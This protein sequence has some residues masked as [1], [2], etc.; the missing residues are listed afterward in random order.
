MKK[1]FKS[2]VEIQKSVDKVK[3]FRSYS[4]VVSIF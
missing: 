1:R 4:S 2:A 3:D